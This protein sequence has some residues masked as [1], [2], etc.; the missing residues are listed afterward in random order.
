MLNRVYREHVA[1]ID[2]LRAQ[3]A[4]AK[5]R[6]AELEARNKHMD[7]VLYDAQVLLGTEDS[8]ELI[9]GPTGPISRLIAR[10][11]RAEAKLEEMDA[12]RDGPDRYG[13]DDVERMFEG[14]DDEGA[15]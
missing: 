13:E 15:V 5:A 2:R 4:E 3:L 11:E 8:G 1:E 14:I 12:M 7:T 9:T 6:I 10:A